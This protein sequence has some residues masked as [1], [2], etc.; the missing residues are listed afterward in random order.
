MRSLDTRV[1]DMMQAPVAAA[2]FVLADRL[3]LDA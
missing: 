1:E 3:G 2:M